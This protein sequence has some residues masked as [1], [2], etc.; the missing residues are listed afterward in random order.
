M[1]SI[2]SL[3]KTKYI[4]NHC[5]LN[6]MKK[7]LNFIFLILLCTFLCSQVIAEEIQIPSLGTFKQG[8]SI[9]LRQ[10]GDS[11][12]GELDSCTI[13]SV[14]YPNSTIAISN[15]AMT[16]ST[17]EF[18]YTLLSNYTNTRGDYLVN[19]Y[20][21]AG[22]N[23]I[24]WSYDF[25]VT[26]TGDIFGNSQALIV[27]AQ[28]GMIG[29]FMAVGFSFGKEK[30]KIRMF[31]FMA[32]LI[33][34]VL[35]INSIRIMLGTSDNLTS[36]GNSALYIGIIVVLVMF[37]YIFVYYTIEVFNYFKNKRNMRWQPTTL[38]Q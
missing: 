31:L 26:S 19:G 28:F 6:N 15:V 7:Y 10:I 25:S 36:M 29:L 9:L 27:I 35:L 21:L 33:M 32:A 14:L 11:G 30:W 38:N 24:T 12:T 20:C 18:N 4:Y 37:L 34:G 22:S 23:V 17:Y 13:T 1:K 3:K 16:K 2:K 8:T 5:Y